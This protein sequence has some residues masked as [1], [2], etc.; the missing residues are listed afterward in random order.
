MGK[1]QPGHEFADGGGFRGG[2]FQELAAHRRVVEQLL[3]HE[4]GALGAGGILNVQDVA[5]LVAHG[6]AHILAPGPGLAGDFRYR[7][8]GGQRF[9]PEAQRPHAV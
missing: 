6:Q 4:G 1:N 9:A 5:A 2:L 8:D 7:R 3:H